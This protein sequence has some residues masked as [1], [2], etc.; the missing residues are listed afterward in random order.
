VVGAPDQLAIHIL[1]DPV[2]ERVVR[3]RTDGMISVDLV[4]DV[5]AAG[6]TPLEI[7]S[8]IQQQIAR[9]KRDA[10]VNVTVESSPSQFVTVFGEVVRPGIFSLD[11]ETRVSEAIG[12]VGGTRPFANLDGIRLIRST[13]QEPQIF[14]IDL[15]A[16]QRGDLSTNYVVD[17]GDLIVVPPTV[18]ARVGY[19]MQALLFP[20]QPFISAASTSGSIYSGINAV[21]GD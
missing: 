13:G 11:T 14:E 4:G 18:F 12:R 5:R 6:R 1:P 10:V 7:A 19:V 16:I 15:Q 17:K 3:V 9:F 2:I 21:G 8:D 20:L